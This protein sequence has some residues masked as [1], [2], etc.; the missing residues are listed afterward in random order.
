MIVMTILLLLLGMVLLSVQTF[1][2]HWKTASDKYQ[3][4]LAGYKNIDLL[5][6]A[7]HG[8]IPQ[9]VR[10]QNG[11][12]GFYFLGD[13]DGFTGVTES[14]VFNQSPS[15]VFRV[16]KERQPDG[17]YSLYYEEAPLAVYALV[18]AAQEHQFNFRLLV[19]KNLQQLDFSYFGWENF[20][21]YNRYFSELTTERNVRWLARYDGLQMRLQP[22]RIALNIGTFRW[23]F[24]APERAE[25]V[26]KRRALENEQ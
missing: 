4:S 9:L 6:S 12:V 1:T 26:K 5:A 14:P 21:D 25:F 22:E 20:D 11:S 16:L 15:A 18:N 24:R 8:Q 23:I 13:Q 3:I 7:L 2:K 17:R 10:S 19:L